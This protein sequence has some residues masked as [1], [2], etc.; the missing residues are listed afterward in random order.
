MY[1]KKVY[2]TKKLAI[3]KSKTQIMLFLTTR[4]SLPKSTSASSSGV[5]FSEFTNCL[6]RYSLYVLVSFCNY[7]V[8]NA[9]L[10]ITV[11]NTARI[12]AL[13]LDNLMETAMATA[14][15]ALTRKE[16]RGAHSR[17]DYPERDDENWLCHSMYDPK[18]KTLSKREVNFSPNQVD[19][20]PPAVRSY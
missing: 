9:I 4:M 18:T 12:E 15:L 10:I 7:G 5:S 19:P 13:E 17:E 3:K 20:F 8:N 1:L 16:S 11:F 2:A 14:V 6:F